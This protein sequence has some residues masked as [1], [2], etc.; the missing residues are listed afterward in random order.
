MEGIGRL[1][2]GVAHD[3]NNLL[4]A[5]FNYLQLATRKLEA[6]HPALPPLEHVREAAERAAALTRQ[7]LAFARTQVVNPRVV[8]AR[9]VARNIEPMLRRLIGEDVA[10][11]SVLSPDT[12]NVRADVS[13]LE[14]VIVNLAVNA[15]DA[16]PSGGTLMLE[17]GNVHLDE[18]YCRTRAGATPG[19]HVMVAV[20][21]TGTGMTPE[22]MGRLFEPFFTTKPP[23]KGTGLGLA[24]CH[25]IVR[26]SGG[27]I[28]VYSEP[29]HGT[30]VKVFL[31][32]VLE[33][34]AQG[35]APPAQGAPRGG[36]ETILLAEDSQTVRALAGDALS[37]SGYSVLVAEDGEK[38][39]RLAHDHK[40]VID[41][42]VTD[43]VMPGLNG[44]QLVQQL[45]K[46]RPN[47]RAIY[48]SGYTEETVGHHGVE[49]EREAFLAKP[50]MT[51]LLLRKVRAVL[52]A[53][54]AAP[55]G[56]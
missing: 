44:V 24:T 26:Q 16:M 19:P 2:G 43:V 34:A 50:F 45:L 31:P 14:Q 11:R 12:G 5:T 27:H 25:G 29:G 20:S 3:F 30:S 41:L 35:E 9:E 18:A 39:L 54:K 8:S 46:T 52:D 22:V 1:A 7:L 33:Q 37:E 10:L 21:D 4:M 6:G 23:G 56:S 13:Q 15:R 47:L 38:A 42:V 17:T 49:A 55:K 32:R 53:G 28:A 48:M 40:G 51:D 36:S